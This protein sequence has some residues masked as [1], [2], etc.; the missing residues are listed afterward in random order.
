MSFLLQ[1]WKILLAIVIEWV[2]REQE[3]A[4]EYL[5]TENQVLKEQLGIGR[6]LLDDDQ[7]RRLAV[8]GQALSRKS[9]R[10]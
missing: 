3:K 8:K 4:I 6:I 5:G 10:R 7:R 9:Y 2:R 1:P